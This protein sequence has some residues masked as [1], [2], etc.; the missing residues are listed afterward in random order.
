MA[1]M[2]KRKSFS[3]V[4]VRN[5]INLQSDVYGRQVFVQSAY[6]FREELR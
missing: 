3:I 1:N 4:N 2:Y 6:L 5:A